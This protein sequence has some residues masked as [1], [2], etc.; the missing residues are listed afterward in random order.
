MQNP[1]QPQPNPEAHHITVTIDGEVQGEVPVEVHTNEALAATQPIPTN[2]QDMIDYAFGDYKP[3]TEQRSRTGSRVAKVGQLFDNVIL[4]V[5]SIRPNKGDDPS[6]K[7][8]K[9]WN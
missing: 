7:S 9:Y 5:G 4:A 3:R 8:S 2:R 1:S 6:I